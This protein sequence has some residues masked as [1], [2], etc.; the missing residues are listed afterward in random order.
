MS[1][2]SFLS[3]Y[4]ESVLP[5]ESVIELAKNSIESKKNT[6]KISL[7]NY[8]KQNDFSDIDAISSVLGRP[9]VIDI[10]F[11]VLL[12]RSPSYNEI[13]DNSFL[14][15]ISLSL[16]NMKEQHIHSIELT[17]NTL[18]DKDKT[19]FSLFS[20]SSYPLA[21]FSFSK[22]FLE[23]TYGIKETHHKHN[24]LSISCFSKKYS[25]SVIQISIRENSLEQ[26]DE[27]A[28]NLVKIYD[29]GYPCPSIQIFEHTL[30]KDQSFFLKYD[31]E[32]NIVSIPYAYGEPY[33]SANSS[34]LTENFK[35]AL[36]FISK[37]LWY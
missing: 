11:S 4:N 15:I 30:S 35:Q 36:I 33:F 16:D 20:T 19:H 25:V 14:T 32:T 22:Q 27:F 9:A 17:F 1:V 5:I 34:D 37:E 29:N 6:L 18:S 31:K 21:Q 3:L 23:D 2:H 7:I 28:R 13:M 8:F 12:E 26:I 10:V 24:Q